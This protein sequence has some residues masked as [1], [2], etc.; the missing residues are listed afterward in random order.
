[1]QPY[2]LPRPEIWASWAL[3][4]GGLGAPRRGP[5]WGRECHWGFQQKDGS[6]QS[7]TGV[8]SA[9][10]GE[11]DL[12]APGQPRPWSDRAIVPCRG[13][14][15]AGEGIQQAQNPGCGHFLEIAQES[16]LFIST[17]FPVC[18]TRRSLLPS[19]PLQEHP[20]GRSSVT[21]ASSGDRTGAGFV[22]HTES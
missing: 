9:D 8:H 1:M 19:G 4:V 14:A 2:L 6:W 13:Q 7:G 18:R 22:G 5:Q 16:L 15:V 21:G 10:Q 11:G 17:S 20:K 3:G 12:R